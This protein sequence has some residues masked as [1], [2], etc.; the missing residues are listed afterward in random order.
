LPATSNLRSLLELVPYFES[1]D[2]LNDVGIALRDVIGASIA[3]ALGYEGALAAQTETVNNVLL[4]LHADLRPLRLKQA[5]A[6]C[7]PQAMSASVVIHGSA[8]ASRGS[9]ITGSPAPM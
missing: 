7:A 5:V 1:V 8:R 4:A 9:R 6:S 2:P 3:M